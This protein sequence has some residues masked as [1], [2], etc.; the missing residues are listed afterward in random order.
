MYSGASGNTT[1]NNN[2]DG[3]FICRHCSWCFIYNE[4]IASFTGPRRKMAAVSQRRK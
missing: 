1:V 4:L 2:K 3:V